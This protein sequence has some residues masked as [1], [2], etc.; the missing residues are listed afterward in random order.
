MEVQV[1]K[2]AS[3]GAPIQVPGDLDAFNCAYCGTHLSVRRGAGYLATGF[4]LR[5]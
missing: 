1:M 5:S 4:Q 2:C 3:C